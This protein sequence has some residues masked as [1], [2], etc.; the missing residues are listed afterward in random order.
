M[1]YP[2]RFRFAPNV[3][4]LAH[5]ALILAACFAFMLMTPN[6]ALA[7]A[8]Y[9]SLVMDAD[10]GLVLHKRNADKVLHPASLTKMMTLIMLFDALEEGR[11]HMKSR[12]RISHNAANAVPSKLDLPVG[13][14]IRVKDAINALIIKSANDVAIAVAEHLAGSEKDFARLMTKRARSLGMTRTRFMN[15]SGLHHKRQVST[16]RDMAKLARTIIS[17]YAP[18]YRYFSANKFHYRGKTYRSHN[19]LM[20]K[21]AG[22]DGM[23]T[24]YIHKSGFNLVSSAVRN[25]RRIIGVVFGGA[26]LALT[27]C[28]YERFA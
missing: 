9:A 13:S 24:G 16:A 4:L 10:T 5:A 25:N 22:M 1:A 11:V 3:K 26:Y 27:K 19:K 20:G 15:A 18:Y 7:N 2:R 6:Q 21:Y 12:I 14:S 28:A 23:K 17:E 8:K